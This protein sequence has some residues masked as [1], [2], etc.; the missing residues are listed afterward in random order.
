[1]LEANKLGW[2]QTYTLFNNGIEVGSIQGSSWSEKGTLVLGGYN[3]SMYHKGVFS[4]EYQLAAMNT[5][6]LINATKSMWQRNHEIDCAEGHFSLRHRSMWSSN[7]IVFQ[8]Q[9][10]IGY[11]NKKSIWGNNAVAEIP[12]FPLVPA[13]FLIW[14]SIISW[15]ETQQ[16][17]RR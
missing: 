13:F 6:V 17:A 5:A 16:A 4:S 14:L 12:N 2:S 3:Y 15:R 1:M 11:I 7:F 10:E 8:N 9:R